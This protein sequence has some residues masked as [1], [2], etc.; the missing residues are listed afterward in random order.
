MHATTGVSPCEAHHFLR[1]DAPALRR[2]CCDGLAN[3]LANQIEKRPIGE[4]VTWNLVSWLSQPSTFFTG[5]RIVSDR[6]TQIPEVKNSGIRQIVVRMTSRQS[7]S[8]STPFRARGKASITVPETPA[9]E[10]DCHE[11]IVIQ[12]II[13]NGKNSG[14]R[15]WGHTV[16]SDID[17]IYND[18]YFQ[19]GLSALERLEAIRN[20]GQK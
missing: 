14:W 6:A 4:K 11:Y 19:P 13:W 18:P 5:I 3:K 1:G 12:E 8:K 20:M 15:V 7:K 10:Q 16:P 2:I 9:K 17:R